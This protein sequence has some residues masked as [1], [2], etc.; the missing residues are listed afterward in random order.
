MSFDELV[1]IIV[2]FTSIGAILFWT[3]GKQAKQIVPEE[4]VPQELD[5]PGVLGIPSSP[6]DSAQPD[7]STGELRQ[8]P[9]IVP[10]SN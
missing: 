2:A 9:A 5:L 6:D 7:S 8:Q 10:Q 4:L 1:A 3:L